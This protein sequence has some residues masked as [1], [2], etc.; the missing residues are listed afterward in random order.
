MQAYFWGMQ[1]LLGHIRITVAVI[2]EFIE[3]ATLRGKRRWLWEGRE[4]KIHLFEYNVPEFIVLLGNFV[5]QQ[6][7]SLTSA[8]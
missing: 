8:V 6:M 4:K 5:C 1:K 2:F 7:E 3:V